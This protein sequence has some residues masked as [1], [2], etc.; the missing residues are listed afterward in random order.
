[1]HYLEKLR[2]M[3]EEKE[4][5]NA[6]ISQLSNVPLPTVTRIFNGSTPNP[7]F[8]T[9]AQIAIALGA[10][11]D[12]IAGLKVPEATPLTSPVETTLNSYA[13]LLKEKDERIRDL[14]DEKEKMRKEKQRFALALAIIV[15]FLILILTVDIMNGHF[16]Y[17]RY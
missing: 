2:A 14:K 4:L 1:M 9:F 13:E 11:L 7:T 3:K 16:G 17:F 8:E 6:E 15:G 5:T 10:S 12:E